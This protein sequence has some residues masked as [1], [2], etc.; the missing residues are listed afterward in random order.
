M[1]NYSIVT[2][3]F[4]PSGNVVRIVGSVL[5]C[6]IIL[7]FLYRYKFILIIFKNC[8]DIVSRKY[9]IK[10]TNKQGVNKEDETEQGGT[11]QKEL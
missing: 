6:L 9:Y 3:S 10:V 7:C 5:N 11:V 1:A 4:Q 8:L 2:V